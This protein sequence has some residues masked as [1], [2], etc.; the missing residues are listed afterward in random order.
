MTGAITSFRIRGL[1]S[2]EENQRVVDD[3]RTRYNLFTVVRTGL[4]RGACV[5]VTPALYNRP[6]DVERLAAA[7]KDPSLGR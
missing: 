1:T 7:L 5:R 4:E 3:L 2:E 6:A